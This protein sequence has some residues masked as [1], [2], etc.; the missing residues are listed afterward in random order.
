MKIYTVMLIMSLTLGACSY[1]YLRQNFLWA[2][3]WWCALAMLLLA[4]NT[5]VSRT[6]PLAVP[7]WLAKTLA[8]I[9]GLWIAMMFY[10]LLLLLCHGAV[11]SLTRLFDVQL[12]NRAIAACG[13]V[14]V[15]LYIAYGNYRAFHPD[16]RVEKVV[17]S[18]LDRG[19]KYRL[20]LLSDIHLG[21]QLGRSYGE[22]LVERVNELQP[23]VILLAGDLLDEKIAYVER[24]DSLAPLAK[25]Q[26]TKGVY[27]CYG[28]HDYLDQPEL[29]QTYVEAV[30]IKVLRDRDI[31]VD[32]KLKIAGLGDWSRHKG[33]KSLERLAQD[34]E[35]YFSI[36][37]DHQPRRIEAIA[38]HGYDLTVSGHTHTGQMKPLRQVTKRMYKLDYGRMEIGDT[39][40][41][42]SNGYGFW[43]PPVRTEVAPEIVVID[44]EGK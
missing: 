43:G 25:L 3:S 32:N 6:L 12:P 10:M 19:E 31:L 16:T 39:V 44:V 40:A 22:K 13:L 37:M 27:M 34:N 8:V 36:I 21:Q 7:N 33:T 14:L 9:N 23:D 42:T 26:T 24:E 15:A 35:K 4:C 41:I 2:R 38:A 17:T 11:Y 1:F 28:N 29:W 30:G 20:V 18:K 5:L